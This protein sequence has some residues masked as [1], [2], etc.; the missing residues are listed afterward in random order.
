[1]PDS[2]G[3]VILLRK[4]TAIGVISLMLMVGLGLP[5][6]PAAGAANL[7]LNFNICP[8]VGP[9]TACAALIV[10]SDGGVMTVVDN[11][12]GTARG[13]YDGNDSLIGVQNNT[14]AYITGFML[15]STTPIFAFDGDGPCTLLAAPTFTCSRDPS[16]YGGSDVN[17][18]SFTNITS[19]HKTAEILFPILPP[20]HDSWF[21][22]QG[23]P[24]A[25]S[26]SFP[27]AIALD[28]EGPVGGPGVPEGFVFSV[29][30]PTSAPITISSIVDTLPPG[31]TYVPGSTGGENTADPTV[32]GSTLTWDGPFVLPCC[33]TLLFGFQATVPST[34]G[35][36]TDTATAP[37]TP[38]LQFP[39]ASI[40]VTV[41]TVVPV[42]AFPVNGL[43][44]AVVL[45]GGILGLLWRRRRRDSSLAA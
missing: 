37:A 11:P 24:D 36:Y 5:L 3:G 10:I 39:T 16:G 29:F 38:A 17:G 2:W 26:L 44:I 18:V 13:V 32:R 15:S 41:G 34:P 21:A 4:G 9:A 12:A 20:Y 14:G 33:S 1:M 28:T 22:V 45:G 35:T 7:P 31:F 25:A 42:P 19:D 8:S 40:K 43:P 6:A 27:T 30:N 23:T